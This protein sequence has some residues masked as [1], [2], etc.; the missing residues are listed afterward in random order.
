M[1]NRNRSRKSGAFYRKAANHMKMKNYMT[2]LPTHAL[3][4]NLMKKKCSKCFS[5]QSNMTYL[6]HA[7]LQ[8]L[9]KK[10][11][12]V[13]TGELPELS[14]FTNADESLSDTSDV[15]DD[16]VRNIDTM[17]IE[18]GL[19][20][21]ALSSNAPHSSVN[22]VL[23]LFKKANV[24]VPSTAQTLLRTKRNPSSEIKEIGG[25]QYW[26]RGITKCLLNYFRSSMQF[27]PIL[28]K[29]NELPK[30]PVMTAAIFCGLKKPDSIDEYLGPLVNEL[31]LLHSNGIK[32]NGE[33]ITITL[34]AIVADTPARAFIKG[35]KGHT[36]Y[37]SCMKCTKNGVFNKESKTTVFCRINAPKKTDEGFRADNYPGYRIIPTPLLQLAQFDMIRD[38]IVADRLHLID[39]GIMKRLL[40]GWRDGKLGIKAWNKQQIEL[41]DKAL[42][43][44][45]QPSEVH[46]KQR[47][48]KYIKYWKASE[49][50]FFLHYPAIAVLKDHL[51]QN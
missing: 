10:K 8:N 45:R 37:A 3:L 11:C 25:G 28:F 31:N 44:I 47:P 36:A 27:W 48:I 19:R 26:Y 43:K 42:D 16:S 30:A 14:D 35:V 51:P 39:L 23:K 9:M 17:S 24:K 38:I 40:L 22:M 32:I 12:R 46:R 13:V 7:L 20:F 6:P 2:Y 50:A 33:L 21:W 34:S 29:I 41:I 18:D 15:E 5:Q 1:A 4:Q 49:C